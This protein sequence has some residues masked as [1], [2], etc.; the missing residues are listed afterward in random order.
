M[1]AMTQRSFGEKFQDTLFLLKNTY[2]LLGQND[3]LLQP[4]IRT[5]QVSLIMATLFWGSILIFFLGN[6][7]TVVGGAGILIAIVL[8]LWSF[9]YFT[10]LK[11]RL[12]WLAC[13]TACGTKPAFEQSQ[14]MLDGAGGKIRLIAFIDI[15]FKYIG[16]FRDSQEEGFWGAIKSFLINLVLQGATEIWDLVS[17]YLIPAIA[18]DRLTLKAAIIEIKDLRN[19]VP[20]VLVGVFGIDFVGDVIAS[21]VGA[22]Y[23]ILIALAFGLVYLLNLKSANVVAPIFI[24]VMYIGVI[25]HVILG[26]AVETTKVIYFTLFYTVLRHPEQMDKRM[27]QKATSFLKFNQAVKYS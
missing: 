9:F 1:R 19:H 16:S 15:F 25:A 18:V 26:A 10:E 11:L 27:K 8:Y 4:L 7:I 21:I 12:S 24:F 3:A 5:I 13:S 23:A 17:H 14:K 20:S 6:K 22:L 2:A